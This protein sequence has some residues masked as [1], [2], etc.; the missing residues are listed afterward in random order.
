[1]A[2]PWNSMMSSGPNIVGRTKGARA[3]TRDPGFPRAY[4]P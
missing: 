3:E 1:M 2:S 4:S